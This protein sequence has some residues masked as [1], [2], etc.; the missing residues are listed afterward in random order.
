MALTLHNAMYSDFN[1]KEF[2]NE[3][4]HLIDSGYGTEPQRT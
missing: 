4:W 3:V 2:L 1:E